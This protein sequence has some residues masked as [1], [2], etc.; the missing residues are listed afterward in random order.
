MIYLI[1]VI[2]ALLAIIDF[3]FRKEIEIHGIVTHNHI[4]YIHTLYKNR[5]VYIIELKSLANFNSYCKDVYL[6]VECDKETSKT[7]PKM[8]TIYIVAMKGC[9]TGIRYKYTIC[10][11]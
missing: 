11:R 9:I 8:S 6:S 2:I 4:K 7:F 3:F 10:D 1:I 5:D